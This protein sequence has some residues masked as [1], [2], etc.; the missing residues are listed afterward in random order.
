VLIAV[1]G[2]LLALDLGKN[3]VLVVNCALS[4]ASPEVQET[5]HDRGSRVET[6][7]GHAPEEYHP[8]G[9][10]SP[11]VVALAMA[12]ASVLGLGFQRTVAAESSC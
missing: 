2:Y 11:L 6:C 3:F 8:L 5:C 4:A 9:E 10:E 7:C 12:L 1:S